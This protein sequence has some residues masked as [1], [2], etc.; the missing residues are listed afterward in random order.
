MKPA[1]EFVQVPSAPVRTWPTVAVPVIVGSAVLTGASATTMR[2][3]TVRWSF[4]MSSIAT[5][6]PGWPITVTTESN[7]SSRV[8]LITNENRISLSSVI[9]MGWT[10]VSSPIP[11]DRILPNVT[12]VEPFPFTS[13]LNSSRMLFESSA[14]PADEPNT[15]LADAYNPWASMSS[16]STS[17]SLSSESARPCPIEVPALNSRS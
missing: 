11:S 17:I 3:A 9:V 4:A 1:G 16:S 6:P 8:T 7:R 14:R 2:S 15:V 12:L 10:N 13:L 5:L